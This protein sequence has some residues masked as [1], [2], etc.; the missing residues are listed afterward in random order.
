MP[1]PTD[2]RTEDPGFPP[3][4]TSSTGGIINPI[5]TCCSHQR[6]VTWPRSMTRNG[7][8]TVLEEGSSPGLA[9]GSL[10]IAGSMLLLH[11]DDMGGQPGGTLA[12]AALLPPTPPFP[13]VSH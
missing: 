10:P 13:P 11:H 2:G 12:V 6:R 3:I 1:A 5:T 7:T 8:T 9:P 4:C